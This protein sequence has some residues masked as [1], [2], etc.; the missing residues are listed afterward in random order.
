MRRSTAS[1]S[2]AE[3]LILETALHRNTAPNRVNDN[4]Q[5]GRVPQE[6][7]G[8]WR[9]KMPPALRPGAV[10]LRPLHAAS[11][12]NLRFRFGLVRGGR[13]AVSPSGTSSLAKS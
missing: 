3:P 9:N 1:S 6:C 10:E 5:V 2:A 12:P 8:G 4:S 11:S 7:G 13:G